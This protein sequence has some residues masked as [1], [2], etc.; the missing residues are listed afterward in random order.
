MSETILIR[1]ADARACMRSCML[2]VCEAGQS[3]PS[4][5]FKYKAQFLIRANVTLH[6]SVMKSHVSADQN[7]EGKHLDN[8]H[9]Q[10]I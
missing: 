5:S 2:A 4:R 9:P 3:A 1:I 10:D 7:A 6:G 8:Q